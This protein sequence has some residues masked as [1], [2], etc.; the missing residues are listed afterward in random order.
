MIIEHALCSTIYTTPASYVMFTIG[1]QDEHTESFTFPPNQINKF[2]RQQGSTP[3]E[4]ADQETFSKD[5]SGAGADSPDLER[6]ESTRKTTGE[7][8]QPAIQTY[9]SNSYPENPVINHSTNPFKTRDE[10]KPLTPA[11]D[12]QYF[13]KSP[14]LTYFPQNNP[15]PYPQNNPPLPQNYPTFT[16]NNPPSP[17]INQHHF[18]QINPSF[19][20]PHNNLLPVISSSNIYPSPPP[21]SPQSFSNPVQ[22]NKPIT[23]NLNL[24]PFHPQG[25]PNYPV[26]VNRQHTKTGYSNKNKRV[27]TN[28]NYIYDDLSPTNPFKREPEPAPA[29]NPTIVQVNRNNC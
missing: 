14:S 22:F 29:G 28:I 5:V 1:K 16:Q 18:P 20:K 24:T 21:L 4:F 26:V 15:A 12:K 7:L 19:P 3:T 6:D 10:E 13:P 23:V 8:Y 9:K 2:K 11:D 27:N 25:R 17:Q